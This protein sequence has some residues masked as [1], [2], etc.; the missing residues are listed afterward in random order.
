MKRS[1]FAISLSM[2]VLMLSGCVVTGNGGGE[3]LTDE[4]K[5]EIEDAIDEAGKAI[6]EA[7]DEIGEALGSVKDEIGEELKNV[8]WAKEFFEDL[9]DGDKDIKFIRVDTGDGSEIYEIEDEKEFIKA[10]D[11]DGWEKKETMPDGLEKEAEYVIKQQGTETIFGKGS[12]EYYE[13]CRLT[14][15]EE[16]YVTFDMLSDETVRKFTDLVSGEWL[17]SVYTVPQETADWLKG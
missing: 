16:N 2:A 12:D 6:N 10:L 4:Q 1:M 8:D 17:T 15:Y 3:K 7:G 14:I 11:A 9:D 5:A 13:I